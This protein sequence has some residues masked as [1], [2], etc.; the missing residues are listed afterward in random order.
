MCRIGH[1][2]TKCRKDIFFPCYHSTD[3]RGSGWGGDENKV[4]A[5]DVVGLEG[6]PDGGG[7]L[8]GLGASRNAAEGDGG[9][10][11]VAKGLLMKPIRTVLKL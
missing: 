2:P 10:G 9:G 3:L 8:K 4:E 1:R 7:D 6:C 11:D 5:A